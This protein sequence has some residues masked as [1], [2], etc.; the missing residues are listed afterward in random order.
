[1]IKLN[2][3]C[4]HTNFGEDWDHIDNINEPHIK[5]HDITKLPYEDNSVDILYSSHTLEY[6]DREEALDVLKEWYRVLKVGGKIYLS[7][8]D[9]R[10]MANLYIENNAPLHKFLGPLFGKMASGDKV[11]YHK[12]VWDYASLGEY[13]RIVGF[14]RIDKWT[15]PD[16]YGFTRKTDIAFDTK[17]D[18]SNANISLNIVATK[19]E[20]EGKK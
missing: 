8:P 11:I 9:F 19:N 16:N 17:D 2:L 12:T 15:Q 10:A 7:V 14:R 1:M 6:F 20:Y 13:L 4:G 5:S 18:C 3:G